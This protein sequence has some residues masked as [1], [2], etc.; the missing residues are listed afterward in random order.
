[1]TAN[2]YYW[3]TEYCS[4]AITFLA[5][6]ISQACNYV[7]HVSAVRN[8]NDAL[9]EWIISN[10]FSRRNLLPYDRT[11]LALR[12]EDIYRARAKA[13]QVIRKGDQGGASLPNSVNLEIVNTQKE[14]S[15]IAGVGHDTIHRVK[16]I[17]AKARPLFKFKRE[18]VM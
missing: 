18:L 5:A 17:E 10:Q 12:L 11:K 7:T 4:L 8:N 1:L 15:K 14:I 6:W 3:L 16:T 13:N 2:Y 9:V